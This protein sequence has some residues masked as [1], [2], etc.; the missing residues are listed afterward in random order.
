M[1]AHSE[2][3]KVITNGRRVDTVEGRNKAERVVGRKRKKLLLLLLL[4]FNHVLLSF[5]LS[6]QALRSGSLYLL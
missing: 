2:W 6:D 5:F 4:L 1:K 3:R